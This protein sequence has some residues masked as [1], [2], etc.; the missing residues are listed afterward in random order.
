VNLGELLRIPAEMFPEQE[1]LR[2]EGTSLDY[3]SLVDGVA[4]TAERLRA[5]GVGPGARVALIDTNSAGAVKALFAAVSLGAVFVPMNFRARGAELAGLLATSEP[6]VVLAG[7][8]Y[9]ETVESTRVSGSLPRVLE[10]ECPDEPGDTPLDA[11]V[12][13][14]DDDVAVLMFTSGTSGA[15]KAAMLTHGGLTGFVLAT[16]EPADGTRR[17][18]TLIAVPLHHVAGLTAVLGAIFAGRRVVLMRQFDAGEWL[19]LVETERVTRAF[20]V[21]TMLK[22]VLDHPSFPQADVSSLELLGY[23]ASPMPQTVIRR[24]IDELPPTVQLVNAFGQTETTSTVTMLTPE[25]HRLVGDPEE[26]EARI[27]RLASIGRPLP[28]VDIEV[29]D[30][31]GRPVQRGEIGEIAV[32]SP[33]LMTGYFGRDEETDLTLR[34]GW[35]RTR[36][37]GWMDEDGYVFLTG[38][39]SDLII[40]GGENVAPDEVEAVLYAHPA[41]SECVVVGIPDEE[42][43]ERIVAAVELEPGASCGEVELLEWCRERL[44]GHKRPERIVLTHELP[45]NAVGK[46]LRREVRHALTEEEGKE[47]Q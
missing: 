37:L 10:L 8:R 4:R 12:E 34:D 39:S 47:Q 6:Q 45:R 3:A 2:F 18:S 20:L 44:A 16:T 17:G 13:V 22:R 25:D 1:I 30:A 29:I 14:N 9:V 21:P 36:D 35:L 19:R 41:V 26:V 24:A 31:D 11:V 15:P 46:L 43:G 23:G 5:A 33:R 27:R 40:R 38:R 7:A 28:D 32:R 42:W